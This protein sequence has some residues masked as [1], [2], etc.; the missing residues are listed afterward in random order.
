MQ[1]F[2]NSAIMYK[3]MK[4]LIKNY[5]KISVFCIPIGVI[6]GILCYIFTFG[7]NFVNTLRN[8][9]IMYFIPFLF[10][11]GIIIV[12]IFDKFDDKEISVKSGMTLVFECGKGEKNRLPL[13]LIPL[14]SIST[15]LTN[16]C[17]GSCG[18][19][20]V[21]VQIGATVSKYFSKYFNIK[22]VHQI[23]L[24]AG[25]GAG[26]SAMFQTPFA[27]IA[28]AMEVITIRRYKIFAL[29]P[30]IIESLVAFGVSYL[31]GLRKETYKV[32][33]ISFLD[34]G[35][36][37]ILKFVFICIV[38]AI[39]GL[40]FST[41][42][43]RLKDVYKKKIKNKY[44]G[45][46]ISGIILSALFLLL[47]YGRYSGTGTNLIN[48]CFGDGKI[49][50]YDFIL[51]ALLTIFTLSVGFQGGEVTPLFTIGATLG[52]AL[53]K[54]VGIDTGLM[55]SL[56]FISVFASATNTYFAPILLGIE[57]FGIN[58]AIFYIIAV[59]IS[60]ILNFDRSIYNQEKM[61]S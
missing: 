1:L 43:E 55:A 58:N 39:C 50:S 31:L 7:L 40:L 3:V 48:S 13:V 27:G 20:G 17:G 52:F 28:F 21:A 29:I 5:F 30:T 32:L 47:H 14:V 6:V 49:Y 25:I 15:W 33:N 22:R 36:N 9:H 45:I 2:I 41:F 10:L 8:A 35:L 4:E 42:L 59:T 18:R 34:F 16:L 46:V 24:I 37:K 60:Y 56:G 12:Y 57:I 11:A 53:S 54:T 44:I 26:F 23:F 61:K 51:K 38:F 19:E